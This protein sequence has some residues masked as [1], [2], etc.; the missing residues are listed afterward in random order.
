MNILHLFHQEP[1]IRA[2]ARAVMECLNDPVL[3]WEVRQD[4][5][6]C[7]ALDFAVKFHN[8]GDVW[9]WIQFGPGYTGEA[10]SHPFNF[11]ERKLVGEAAWAAAA[12]TLL[13]KKEDYVVSRVKAELHPEDDKNTNDSCTL[14]PFRK[15]F[16]SSTFPAGL[17]SPMQGVHL[18]K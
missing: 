5:V 8:D 4:S 1:N 9:V 13:K 11:H 7:A 17:G 3:T 15:L 2:Y 10:Q 18:K 12:R 16:E 6:F 14:H